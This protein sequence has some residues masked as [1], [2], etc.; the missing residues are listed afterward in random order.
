MVWRSLF[1][2][3]LNGWERRHTRF[4]LAME[5]NT[6]ITMGELSQ[7][8]DAELAAK[9]LEMLAPYMARRS[10]DKRDE[11]ESLEPARVYKLAYEV[12]CKD[13]AGLVREYTVR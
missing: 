9:T 4:C 7:I 13:I 1:S 10:W 5:K 6:Q 3:W 12:A 8:F 11:L 2:D